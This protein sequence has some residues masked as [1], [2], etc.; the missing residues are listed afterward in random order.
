MTNADPLDTWTGL[1][2]AIMTMEEDEC[3]SLLDRERYAGRRRLQ[4]MLRIHS[5]INLL[6]AR[7]ERAELAAEAI[8]R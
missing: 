8:K 7:R 4:F 5:R 2:A 6:R 3:H 1:N